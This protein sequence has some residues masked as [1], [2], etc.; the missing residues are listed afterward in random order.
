M[1]TH[2]EGSRRNVDV[3]YAQGTIK[4]VI[5]AVIAVMFLSR[6]LLT[7]AALA[8]LASAVSLL[9]VVWLV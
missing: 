1:I 6:Q 7:H 8:G 3:T 9:Q 4:I 2:L 5:M